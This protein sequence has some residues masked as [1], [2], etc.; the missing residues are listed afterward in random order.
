MHGAVITACCLLIVCCISPRQRTNRISQGAVCLHHREICS[1]VSAALAFVKSKR[2]IAAPNSGFASQLRQFVD[3]LPTMP[4]TQ[5]ELGID[6]KLEIGQADL[7]QI[8]G[9][10]C[11][12][13]QDSEQHRATGKRNYSDEEPGLARHRCRQRRPQRLE[14]ALCRDVLE[15]VQ[16]AYGAPDHIR[17]GCV[18][19]ARPPLQGG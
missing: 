12:H 3:S 9:T 4:N 2:E 17:P 19:F 15:R 13:T 11:R 5:P 10:G 8:E 16:H 7:I 14:N 18:H 1:T 6:P